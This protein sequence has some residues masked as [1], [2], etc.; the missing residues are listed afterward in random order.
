M[1]PRFTYYARLTYSQ[2]WSMTNKEKESSN[3][4]KEIPKIA[5]K[6]KYMYAFMLPFAGAMIYMAFFVTPAWRITEPVAIVPAALMVVCHCTLPFVLNPHIV[7]AVDQYSVD[8]KTH[9][10]K[11]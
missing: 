5:A 1:L 8:D 3:F 2:V 10:E 9:I 7:S 6:F 11:A 4:F